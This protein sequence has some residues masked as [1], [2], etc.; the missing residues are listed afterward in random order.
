LVENIVTIQNVYPND[1]N[2]VKVAYEEK[3]SATGDKIIKH[4][5]DS[6][7]RTLVPEILSTVG[8][9]IRSKVEDFLRYRK[10]KIK[11]FTLK[12]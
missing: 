7:K 9:T 5:Y 10:S 12:I 6:I 8:Q 4:E 11:K 1:Q 3:L 2:L